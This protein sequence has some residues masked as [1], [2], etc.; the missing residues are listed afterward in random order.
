MESDPSSRVYEVEVRL[1][2][3]ARGCDRGAAQRVRKAMRAARLEAYVRY[4][5]PLVR[6]REMMTQWRAYDARW[7]HQAQDPGTRDEW[8]YRI[9]SWAARGGWWDTRIR[10]SGTPREALHLAR[11][12]APA[13]DRTSHTTLAVRPL[14][15]RWRSPEKFRPEDETNRRIALHCV[16]L[17]AS[18]AAA[19]FA[20]SSTGSGWW[21]WGTVTVVAMAAGLWT[22]IRIHRE[23]WWAGALG[24]V[25][26]LVFFL[27]LGL[28]HLGEDGQGWSRQQV[29]FTGL[30]AAVLV[31][32]WLLVRQ[33]TWGEWVAWAVPLVA[34][35]VASSFIAAGSVLHAI[36]A[37]TL[38]LSPDDLEVPP[39][40]QVAA[41]V[42]LLSLLSVIMLLPAWWGFARHWHHP[43]AS[44]GE[45]FNGAL[46]VLLLLVFVLVAAVRATHSA[47]AAVDK[48]VAAAQRGENP[49]A[50]FGVEPAW[51]CV[52][53]T[54]AA[55]RL[56]GEGPRLTPSRPYLSFGVAHGTAIL[57]DPK[58]REPVK[59]SASQ[60]RLLPA[61]SGS[62]KCHADGGERA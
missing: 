35:L 58:T 27:A 7:R 18:M 21:V 39:I 49:P 2:G 44:P 20:F 42:K 47:E 14:D 59:L 8:R 22:G 56:S 37:D 60:V 26:A 1:F 43:Y 36:Y 29:F 48:T 51:T 33:W 24:S 55:G 15:G 45:R 50:Y 19:V 31:G 38:G 17:F 9:K 4:A 54:V 5:Q 6:D 23:G 3:S 34:S 25:A 62:A 10:V 53:R 11:R 28:G 40:W 52:E 12:G 30:I 46:Y 61:H 57:W 16:G 32:L 13:A 41:A